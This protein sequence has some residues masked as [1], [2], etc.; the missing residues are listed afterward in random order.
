QTL[1]DFE[2]D[3]GRIPAFI[4][5]TGILV[6]AED[7]GLQGA[8]YPVAELDSTFEFTGADGRTRSTI[9]SQVDDFAEPVQVRDAAGML[10]RHTV[11]E[12]TGAVQFP[13]QPGID[14]LVSN[15]GPDDA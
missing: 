14:Y 15:D 1:A 7:E 4:G 3:F 11:D 10:V 5:G 2:Q 6:S 8:V 13:I 12:V 9:T